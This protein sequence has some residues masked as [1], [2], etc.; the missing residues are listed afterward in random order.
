MDTNSANAVIST[1]GF[2]YLAGLHLLNVSCK[3][4][5]HDWRPSMSQAVDGRVA[6]LHR[7]PNL[8][9]EMSFYGFWLP[10]GLPTTFAADDSWVEV[11]RIA[12][13]WRV[14]EGGAYGCWFEICRGSGVAIH[15]GRSLRAVNRSMLATLLHLN[16]NEVFAKP[17]RGR[18]HLWHAYRNGSARG[19]PPD[20]FR[21]VA[22]DDE[23][24]LRMRYF[25]NNPW[26]LE[27]KAD[28][29]KPAVELGYDTIQIYHELCSKQPWR[30]ACGYEIISCHRSCLALRN[31][32]D[33]G[34]CVRGMPMRT[35]QSLI[36]TPTRKKFAPTRNPT[37]TPSQVC[38]S[39]GHA[40][41]A[42]CMPAC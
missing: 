38:V 37:C 28:L 26:R 21:G 6:L 14:G 39:T 41:A 16:V 20:Q 5:F 24:G 17:V 8:I 11:L 33:R 19:W 30:R 4:S 18:N 23:A 35:G 2:V 32:R 9:W 13:H 3:A 29:C 12:P 34:A 7:S 31:R 42:I 15:V 27:A 25:D 10:D 36:P 22:L 1:L 40:H